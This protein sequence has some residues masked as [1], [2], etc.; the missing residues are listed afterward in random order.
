MDG[1]KAEPLYPEQTL[2]Q[3]VCQPDHGS[4][5]SADAESEVWTLVATGDLSSDSCVRLFTWS[6]YPEH[7]HWRM[8]TGRNITDIMQCIR[9]TR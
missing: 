8:Q 2:D 4:S 6:Q 5:D 7:G 1:L 3:Y 9:R